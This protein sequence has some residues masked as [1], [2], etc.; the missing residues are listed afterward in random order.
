MIN[1]DDA[2]EVIN[3]C[4]KKTKEIIVCAIDIGNRNFA[5]C[6]EKIDLKCKNEE[7][8]H[9]GDIIL[10]SKQDF[11]VRTKNASK[12]KEIFFKCEAFLD[13][14]MDS[15]NKCDVILIEQQMRRN[16]FAQKLEMFVYSYF[17]FKFRNNKHYISYP[18]K[19]KTRVLDAP[20]D[21]NKPQRKKWCIEKCCEILAERGDDNTLEIIS[22][23]KSKAD[24]LCDTFCM[25]QSWKIKYNKKLF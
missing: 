17:L 8:L 22:K 18:A 19:N 3:E 24:D 5:I 7:I 11:G 14:I 12:D 15:L 2:L 13:S 21:L 25:I 4:K 23:N 1:Y 20:K 10:F 9:T 6:M 16:P